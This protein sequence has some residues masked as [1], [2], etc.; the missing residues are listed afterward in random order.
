MGTTS[1]LRLVSN[2]LSSVTL[3]SPKLDYAVESLYS[4]GQ[5]A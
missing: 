3:S 4:A 5:A 2:I 1:E